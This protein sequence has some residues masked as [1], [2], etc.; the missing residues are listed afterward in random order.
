M[1]P[2]PTEDLMWWVSE[3]DQ[4]RK[5]EAVRL[6]AQYDWHEANRVLTIQASCRPDTRVFKAH[7]PP[8]GACN[9]MTRALKL[10]A[11]LQE[12]EHFIELVNEGITESSN[13]VEE[14]Q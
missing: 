7:A 9:N 8:L 4:S 5:K 14:V 12:K 2:F 13:G 1:T 11:N 3:G 10:V 6:V